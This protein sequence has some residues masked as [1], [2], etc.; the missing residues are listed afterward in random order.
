[1]KDLSEPTAELACHV[2]GK[3]GFE[4][5]LVGYRVR[6]RAGALMT[7]L[8]SFEEVVHLLNDQF[9]QLS[10]RRLEEWLRTVIGDGELADRIAEVAQEDMCDR[11]RMLR[12][13]M[14]MSAR[15]CQCKMASLQPT[16][17]EAAL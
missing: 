6:Q 5:R 12:V 7:P 2:T 8:Y 11:D 15:L 10:L 17:A 13:R 4:N 14:L 1:M 3:V 16:G 9:P